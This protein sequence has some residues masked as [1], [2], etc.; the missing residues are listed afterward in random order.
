MDCLQFWEYRYDVKVV[1][2]G[3]G[4]DIVLEFLKRG[5]GRKRRKRGG[6]RGVRIWNALNFQKRCSES[7]QYFLVMGCFVNNV[8]QQVKM[9]QRA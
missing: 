7:H 1:I 5:L 4:L 2:G 9:C 8:A 3:P 6:E